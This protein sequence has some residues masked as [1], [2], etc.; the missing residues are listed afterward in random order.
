MSFMYKSH[1]KSVKLVRSCGFQVDADYKY[2]E[3]IDEEI[4]KYQGMH[5]PFYNPLSHRSVHIYI[6]HQTIIFDTIIRLSC[7]NAFGRNSSLM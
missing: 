3:T 7:L 6:Q 1:N 5:V 2:F 4:E